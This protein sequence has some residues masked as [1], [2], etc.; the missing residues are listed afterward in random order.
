[1]S[2]RKPFCLALAIITQETPQT[3]PTQ[4]PK[5]FKGKIIIE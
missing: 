4:V 1:M 3:A 5:E 2:A